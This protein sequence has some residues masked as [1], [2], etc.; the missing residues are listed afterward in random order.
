ML[1]SIDNFLLLYAK[2]SWLHNVG[3]HQLYRA[4]ASESN[5]L[6]FILPRS[7]QNAEEIIELLLLIW[8]L[9]IWNKGFLSNSSSENGSEL[10][11]WCCLWKSKCG[12]R[13]IRINIFHR[14]II[15]ISGQDTS[16]FFFFL[17]NAALCG[18]ALMDTMGT[19]LDLS[20]PKERLQGSAGDRELWVC[21]S[22]CWLCWELKTMSN[23]GCCLLI[24]HRIKSGRRETI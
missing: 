12:S 7:R 10:P 8:D 5:W 3:K 15:D 18:C 23:H 21:Q 17:Q 6:K 2:I 16:E 1:E 11:V 14:E 24:Y 9:T 20:G 4:I 22:L 13:S 19:N